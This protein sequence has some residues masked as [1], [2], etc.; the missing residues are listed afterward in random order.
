VRALGE[1]VAVLTIGR[2]GDDVLSINEGGALAGTT[3]TLTLDELAQA[4]A[5]LGELFS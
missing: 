4:Y 3:L 1:R 5:A 2:V